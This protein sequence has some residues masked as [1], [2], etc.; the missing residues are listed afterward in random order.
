VLCCD[1]KSRVQALDRTQQGVPMKKERA[2]AMTHDDKCNGTTLLFAALNRLDG[3]VIAQCQ[4]RHR[5]IEWLKFLKQI[6]SETPQDKTLHLICDNYT[7]HKQPKVQ[8]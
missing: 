4:Q 6:D 7:T 2:A 5:H 1:E 3:Q 8:A